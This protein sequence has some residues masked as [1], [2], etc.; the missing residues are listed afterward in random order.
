MMLKNKNILYTAITRAKELVVLVGTEI[1]LKGM[2]QNISHARRNSG[3]IHMF[4]IIE[5]AF[6]EDK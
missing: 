6:K 4:K 1:Q 5:E 3:L 2:I